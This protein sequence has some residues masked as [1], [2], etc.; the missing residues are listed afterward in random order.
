MD[1]K[2]TIINGIVLEMSNTL[3]YEQL[4]QLKNCLTKYLCNVDIQSKSTQLSTLSWVEMN[5]KAFNSFKADLII[6][7]KSQKTIA[8]YER[9]TFKFLN[10]Y[11]KSYLDITCDDIKLY[12]L[13]LEF[14][15]KAIRTVDNTR[16]YINSFFAWLCKNDYIAKNPF[17]KIPRIKQTEIKKVILTDD[18]T[19]KLR[20]ACK[21][22]FETSLVDF[23]H[24]T[25]LRVGEI[26]NLKLSDI[27]I[28]GNRLTVFATKTGRYRVLKLNAKAMKHL[29]DYRNSLDSNRIHNDYLFLN[30]HYEKAQPA[31]YQATLQRIEQRTDINKHLTVHVFRKTL[32]TILNDKGCRPTTIAY[33]MGHS[34]FSTTYKSY[35]GINVDDALHEFSKC[36]A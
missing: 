23:L 6:A 26:S 12:L 16:C 11:S 22:P 17:D 10:S 21:T 18:D 5:Q 35:M 15:N 8:Q 31:T 3:Q 20:D 9:T 36:I 32:A 19:E 1:T 2:E 7:R 24:C 29:V 14:N 25:G 30:R 4:N 34:N 28:K 13:N 33:I 27:D